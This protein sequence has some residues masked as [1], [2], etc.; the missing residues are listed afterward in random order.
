M[1]SK[2]SRKKLE[3]LVFELRKL[4]LDSIQE[5]NEAR[6]SFYLKGSERDKLKLSSEV[7]HSYDALVQYSR[8]TTGDFSLRYPEESVLESLYL[9]K[10]Y[11]IA[12]RIFLLK[13]T[14][15]YFSDSK[16]KLFVLNTLSYNLLDLYSLN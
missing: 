16:T 8:Q 12:N 1:L 7:K 4:L 3:T 6:Y 11:S 10:A 15:P 13:W 9:E 2:E 14:P 5:N